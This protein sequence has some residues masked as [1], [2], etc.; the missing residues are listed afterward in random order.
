M[1]VSTGELRRATPTTIFLY[2]AM[3]VHRS[4]EY[5]RASLTVTDIGS[6]H[7]GELSGHLTVDARPK[8][9]VKQCMYLREVPWLQRYVLYRSFAFLGLLTVRADEAAVQSQHATIGITPTASKHSDP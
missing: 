3:T 9:A 8:G 5:C 6:R 2:T 1:Y 4:G 7:Y